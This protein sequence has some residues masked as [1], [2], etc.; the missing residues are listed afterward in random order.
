MG[1]SFKY[2]QSATSKIVDAYE[3]LS[4]AANRSPTATEVAA[5]L[6]VS[7]D[8]ARNLLSRARRKGLIKR[9]EPKRAQILAAW[10]SKRATG[11]KLRKL[12]EYLTFRLLPLAMHLQQLIDSSKLPKKHFS[13]G[14]L[15]A[16]LDNLKEEALR[17]EKLREHLTK[18]EAR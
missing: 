2:K 14:Q 16:L 18:K 8:W 15:K 11:A 1:N 6:G 17:K 5:H 13:H 7:Y 4:S 10:E 12:D 9:Y 3:T